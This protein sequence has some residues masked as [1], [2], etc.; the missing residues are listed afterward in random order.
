MTE[1]YEQWPED[2]RAAYVDYYAQVQQYLS[3]F[4]FLT[5]Y[6]HW[7]DEPSYTAIQKN[8]LP[9]AKAYCAAGLGPGSNWTTPGWMT[10]EQVNSF[11]PW[12]RD[13]GMYQYGYPNL[14]RF[15]REGSV[16]LP[17]NSQVGFTRGGTGLAVRRRTTTAASW[18]GRWSSR[19]RPRISSAPD[20]SG[21]AGCTT[22]T[23]PPRRGSGWAG[24]RASVCW[25]TGRPTRATPRST[26]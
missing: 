15:L 20:R 14:Q 8:Y 26:C 7:T 9:R 16:K 2:W 11:A 1:P 22:W 12:T 19:G 18:G 6:P 17:A 21:K 3:E 25:R 13:F 24:C 5:A 10:P 4:G 23:S